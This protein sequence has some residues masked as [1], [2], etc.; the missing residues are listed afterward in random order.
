LICQVL[1]EAKAPQS[2]GGLPDWMER[3]GLNV[4]IFF[5][6]RACSIALANENE[7]CQE[8]SCRADTVAFGNGLS[9]RPGSYPLASFVGVYQMILASENRG[10]RRWTMEFAVKGFQVVSAPSRSSCCYH[11]V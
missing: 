5:F 2:S 8:R 6:F 1:E 4:V 10:S 3:L 9:F 7:M 11:T